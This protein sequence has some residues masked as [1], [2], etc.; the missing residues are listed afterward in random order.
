ME[1]IGQESRGNTSNVDIKK[2]K[3]E[4]VKDYSNT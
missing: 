1:N 4:L 3:E 2:A